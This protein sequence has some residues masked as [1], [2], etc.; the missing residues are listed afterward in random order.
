MVLLIAGIISYVGF[1]EKAGTVDY[2]ANAISS[3]GMS[4]IVALLLCFT[5]A[6]VSAFASSTAL[7]GAIIPLAFPFSFR[8]LSARSAGLRRPPSRRRSSTPAHSRPMVPLC[9]QFTG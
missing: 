7:L 1:M 5:A 6:I 4:L 3:L 8:D 9:R 2:V